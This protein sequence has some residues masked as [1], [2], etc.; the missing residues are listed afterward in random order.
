MKIYI[1]GPFFNDKEI[2]YIEKTEQI[3]TS[4]GYSY[5]SPRSIDYSHLGFGSNEWSNSI[6]KKDI[7]EI[8]NCDMMIVLYH[9][10]YSDSGTAFEIGYAYAKGIQI[11]LVHVDRE[12]DSNL[13]CHEG[14]NTNIYFDELA[15]FDF[16]NFEAQPFTGKMF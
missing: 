11:V 9:G 8:D 1:A 15:N 4:K 3:L 2:Q 16:E 6:F 13:M 14:C 7:L 10:N 12:N 5:F